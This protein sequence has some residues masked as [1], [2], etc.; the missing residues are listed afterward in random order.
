MCNSKTMRLSCI[1]HANQ[2]PWDFRILGCVTQELQDLSC[3]LQCV[4]QEPWN[5]GFILQYIT[6]EPWV[7]KLHAAM[8]NSRIMSPKL[9]T[10]M[11]NS[12]IVILS[13]FLQCVTEVH[14][15]FAYVNVWLINLECYLITTRLGLQTEIYDW[16]STRLLLHVAMCHSRTS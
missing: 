12:R 1:L 6:H 10:A 3:I 11:C 16:S 15:L 13:Y 5:L 4:P 2:E 9:H 14:D 8:Y 7:F